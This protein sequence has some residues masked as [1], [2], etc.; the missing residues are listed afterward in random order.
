[1]PYV[2]DDW[3]NVDPTTVRPFTYDFSNRIPT[4][5]AI[6]S[7][8]WTLEVAPLPLYPGADST[9]ASKL[10][11]PS[12]AVKTVT[13]WGG[14]DF[15]AGVRYRLTAFIVSQQGINDDLFSYISVD[16]TP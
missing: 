1:M 3:E 6:A 11:A 4:D 2:G 8:T 10:S 14:P 16:P 15:V 5:D 9:P 12:V 13:T 7:A